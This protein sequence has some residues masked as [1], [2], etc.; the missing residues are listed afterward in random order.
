MAVNHKR[1]NQKHLL[2]SAGTP[3]V[4]PY[5]FLNVLPKRKQIRLRYVDYAMTGAYYVTLCSHKK[6]CIFSSVERDVVILTPL[7]KILEDEWKKTSVA[8]KGVLV[9]D[10]VVMPNHLHGILTFTDGKSIH[11][12][13]DGIAPLRDFGGSE[14]RSLSTVIAQVKSIVTKRA[15]K[16]LDIRKENI[17]QRGFYEHI[18]RD[19][20]DMIRIKDYIRSNPITWHFDHENPNT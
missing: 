4:C 7:G 18:I 17:W 19:E 13:P 6:E 15:K 8:R 9:E 5:V 1:N 3:P 20:K 16:E 2:T 12:I 10:F 14:G 11:E